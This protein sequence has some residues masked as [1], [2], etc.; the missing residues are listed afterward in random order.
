MVRYKEA[1]QSEKGAPIP[2]GHLRAAVGRHRRRVQLLERTRAI[3][4]R[5]LHGIPDDWGTA[6]NVQAMVFGNMGDDSPPGCLHAQSAPPASA[7]STAS[8]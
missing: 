6:V 7:N 4:Y 2:A 5:R 1:V 3:T 8:T